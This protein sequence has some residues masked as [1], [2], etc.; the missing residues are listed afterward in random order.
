MSIETIH[1][2]RIF[3]PIT[4]T[5]LALYAGASGDINAAHIDIDAARAAG[6][7]DVFAQGMLVMAYM[8]SALTDAVRPGRLRSFSSKFTAVTHLGDVLTCKGQAGPVFVEE[9]ER[10][11]IVD[12]EIRNQ[13]GEVKLTGKAVCTCEREDRHEEA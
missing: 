13:H 7:D 9:G 3:P 4:R 6:F 12:L 2:D 8:G 5:T 10:R 11:A 1:I